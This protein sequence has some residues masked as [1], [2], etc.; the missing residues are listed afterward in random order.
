MNSKHSGNLEL[1]KER[2]LSIYLYVKFNCW[3]RHVLPA[4]MRLFTKF[5]SNEY[6]N[7]SANN[8]AQLVPIGMPIVC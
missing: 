6:K 2:T 5:F 7:M 4:V 3:V 1:F 8:G